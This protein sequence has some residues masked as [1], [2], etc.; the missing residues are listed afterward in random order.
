MQQQV[1]VPVLANAER[2][3]HCRAEMRGYRFSI[4]LQQRVHV[5][6]KIKVY[7]GRHGVWEALDRPMASRPLKGFTLGGHG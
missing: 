3:M 2:P 7:A 1:H 6:K 4:A 5:R